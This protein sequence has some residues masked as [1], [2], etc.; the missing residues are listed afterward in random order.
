[1]ILLGAFL[2]GVE[3]PSTILAL[4]NLARTCADLGKH[5]GAEKLEEQGLGAKNRLLG[6]GHPDKINAMESLAMTF[7]HPEN[8]TEAENFNVQ[9]LNARNRL[10]EVEHSTSQ[11]SLE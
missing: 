2:T 1:M 11:Y 3:H 9:V 4:A 7:H 10:L 5:S 8:Y 6:E